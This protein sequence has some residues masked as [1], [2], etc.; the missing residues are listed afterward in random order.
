MLELEESLLIDKFLM[1]NLNGKEIQLFLARI[2]DEEFLSEVEFAHNLKKAVIHKNQQELKRK[3][4]SFHQ[5][6]KVTTHSVH[7]QNLIK[8]GIAASFILCLLLTTY[9]VRSSNQDPYSS[10]SGGAGLMHSV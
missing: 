9:F 8:Y 5:E 10:H 4:N 3:L 1:N 7:M 6:R 2:V